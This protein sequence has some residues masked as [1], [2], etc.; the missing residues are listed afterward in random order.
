MNLSS[1]VPVSSSSAENP[2]ASNG[3]GIL[4][5]TGKPESRK[6]RNSKSDAASSSQARLQDAYL[7]GLM[8]T[9]TEKLVATKEESGDVDLSESETGSLLEEEVTE[10]PVAC[11]TATG[12][13]NAF[14]KSDHSRN[15][16][17]ERKEWPHNLHVSPAT[18]HHPEAVFSIVRKIYR[19][20]H[21]DAMDDLDVNMA[22]WDK[23]LN[24]TLQA[25][26]HLGQDY[27]ANLRFV[28][29]SS[30]EYCGTVVQWK[31]KTDQWTNR[32]HWC[33]RN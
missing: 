14:N 26:V 7:G 15:P 33:E 2:I 3:P 28:K 25:T 18:V 6:R 9:A 4:K 10:R 24:T 21:D 29:K 30:L 27:E 16:K 20:E 19:R 5:A 17:A 13:P 22:I 1:H 11:K 8:D 23:F 12:K 31:W 32:N